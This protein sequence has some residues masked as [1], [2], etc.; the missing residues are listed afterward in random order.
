MLESLISIR[1]AEIDRNRIELLFKQLDSNGTVDK[2]KAKTPKWSTSANDSHSIVSRTVC[3]PVC[4]VVSTCAYTPV[5]STC[6]ST[7]VTHALQNN[8]STSTAYRGTG[9]RP[10]THQLPSSSQK[11]PQQNLMTCE[12]FLSIFFQYQPTHPT[13]LCGY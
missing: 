7:Q 8:D 5:V 12:Q 9:A 13:S 1:K 4:S 3:N 6:A 2:K 10:K 11:E